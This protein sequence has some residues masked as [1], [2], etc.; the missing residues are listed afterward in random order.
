MQS[1]E[2]H[3]ND[4]VRILLGNM[5][6]EFFVEVVIRVAFI[7]VLVIFCIRLMGK[8]MASQLSR[9]ELV[10][11]SSL[12][13]S[14]GIPIQTPDRGLLP[15]LLVAMIVVAAQRIV[16]AR[17]SQNERFERQTQGKISILVD[18]CCLN[19]QE[20]MRV[21]IGRQEIFA[22]LRAL[23]VKHLGQVKRLYFEAKGDFTLVRNPE[24]APG[25]TVLPAED[26]EFRKAQRYSQEEYVCKNCGRRTMT[27]DTPCKNCASGEF[28]RPMV[29]TLIAFAFGGLI[30]AL[31]VP[32]RAQASGGTARRLTDGQKDT[33]ARQ[34]DQS[35]GDRWYKNC[36]IYNLDVHTFQDGDGDGIGDFRG[37]T[38]RLEYLKS[39]G[40]D[41]IWLAPFQPSP[42][43]DDGYDVADYYGI[44]TAC[45]SAGDFSAFLYRAHNIGMRVI[46]D[47]VLDHSSDQH[48]WFLQASA[49]S[50]SRYH[51]W[52]FWSRD[53][54]ANQ[55][56][57]VA[58][59]G[60]QKEVWTWQPRAHEY[61]YHKFYDFQ[62][63]LNLINPEVLAESERI[64]GYWLG[65][66]IDGFRLDAV[67]F[68]VE[69]PR[70]D[71]IASGHNL[72]L[73]TVLRQFL[74]WRKADVLLLGEANVEPK[75]ILDYFGET[76]D[77]LHMLFNFYGNQYLF[78]ALASQDV[79]LLRK[80]M[81]DT[82][83][84]M[85][86]SQWSWFLRNHDE[87]DLGRLTD[88]QRNV[89]YR[90]FGPDKNMQLYDRGI[91][92]RLAPM[93][94]N[95]R[96]LEMAYSLL[97]SLPGTPELHY[98]EELGMGDDLDLKERLSVR[99][100]MPW[101]HE[102]NAG[103]TSS[104]RPIRPLVT[105]E[106][107][108]AHLNVQDEERDPHSLLENVRRLAQCRKECPEIGLGRWSIADSSNSGLLVLR[109]DFE[110]RTLLIV[111]NFSSEPQRL[112]IPADVPGLR[113]LL[114]GEDV[115][116]G[117][118]IA[119]PGYGYRWFRVMG[120][121]AQSDNTRR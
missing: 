43:R 104:V 5:P 16:A 50:N 11:I 4:W 83:D 89:V 1:W 17:L 98:G 41:V 116:P 45:G 77:Q 111:H 74:Q 86:V 100:P 19:V 27:I 22:R 38:S 15:A 84:I 14:I 55:Y 62:P 65:Q 59:P 66:G 18:D 120:S 40:V 23:R 8:R 58:F 53:R 12:A 110:G 72:S 44:D 115:G 49:D 67:P 119:L 105:G 73:I 79:R 56:K 90:Q 37:L 26:E 96:Q 20:M 92:R 63:H 80:A 9:N 25:L 10:A 47:M 78:Y 85:P 87:I 102:T 99:T 109:Y 91:R 107:G 97:F 101:T 36:F 103:F 54:P 68:M 61:Y 75:E 39:L 30:L 69:I 60:V 21:R 42:H 6:P 108:Y 29:N 112:T 106:Y 82:R 2:I 13:A 64:L 33:L 7:Y 70:T 76:G 94:H 71:T 35:T 121:G 88:S 52:Y 95:P 28:E 3:W 51:N 34:F 46:M 113:D 93:L 117:K 24:A 81:T 31:P 32:G 118:A 57:G 48:P 114:G